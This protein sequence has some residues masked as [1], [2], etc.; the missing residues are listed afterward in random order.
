MHQV[1][2]FKITYFLASCIHHLN[3]ELFIQITVEL[4]A[5][6]SLVWIGPD[7]DRFLEYIV[8]LPAIVHHYIGKTCGGTAKAIGS[9]IGNPVYTDTCCRC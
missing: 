8:T 5:E 2:K 1:L 9:S 7:T 3:L 6:T 4:Q